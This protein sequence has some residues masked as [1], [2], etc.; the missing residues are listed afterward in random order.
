MF[1]SADDPSK[2]WKD[3]RRL[4]NLSLADYEFTKETKPEFISE[5]GKRRQ[6]ARQKLTELS[7]QDGSTES[8]ELESHRAILAQTI[9]E[10]EEIESDFGSRRASQN[11][12]DHGFNASDFGD[13]LELDFDVIQQA[14][15]T[16]KNNGFSIV[17]DEE[18]QRL[19]S[20]QNR[21][22]DAQVQIEE[23][24]AELE[25]ILKRYNENRDEFE[26]NDLAEI[27][28]QHNRA[29]NASKQFA[30]K[31]ADLE[32]QI[33][34]T[35]DA[36]Q[37]SKKE[38]TSTQRAASNKL[39]AELTLAQ[40][41]L[42]QVQTLKDLTVALSDETLASKDGRNDTVRTQIRGAKA[43]ANLSFDNITERISNIEAELRQL[44]ASKTTED[45]ELVKEEAKLTKQ[46][47]EL[48]QEIRDW[49]S[50]RE[51][52]SY[53]DFTE[54]LESNLLLARLSEGS[55]PGS[56]RNFVETIETL[57]KDHPEFYDIYQ[58]EN[59]AID[60]EEL[61]AQVKPE[62]DHKPAI[63]PKPDSSPKK[64]PVAGDGAETELDYQS[65]KYNDLKQA[66]TQ[67]GHVSAIDNLIML[68][69]WLS[70]NP[71][72]Q[73]KNI[74]RFQKYLREAGCEVQDCKRGATKFTVV[75][76]A[77]KI[78]FTTASFDSIDHV[79]KNLTTAIRDL[80]ALRSRGETH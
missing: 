63:T 21:V 43:L 79:A 70:A 2:K 24:E 17:G 53:T 50:V 75:A 72:Q 29:R 69:D 57:L 60:L 23:L 7:T 67:N 34:D 45:P 13:D 38:A 18:T 49:W 77:H 28:R 30:P 4:V 8:K 10:L 68:R 54:E 74:S 51:D 65:M 3:A 9:T 12:I 71:H 36:I 1:I 64:L 5:Q 73:T 37:S 44:S 20:Q 55:D 58:A 78:H 59:Y 32:Q 25:T 14:F 40:A 66:Y 61:R 80:V 33:K 39:K 62:A 56:Y 47:E 48:K 6:A 11:L 16:A 27:R 46:K 42:E 35:K 41:E 19:E 52:K 15:S 31:L 22:L 26:R 76:D